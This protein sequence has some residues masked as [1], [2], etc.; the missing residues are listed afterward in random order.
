MKKFLEREIKPGIRL[1]NGNSVE[2][3]NELID[4]FGEGFADCII[5]DP[6]YG[7]TL[8]DE[9]KK[10]KIPTFKSADIWNIVWK[11]VKNDGAVCLF[12]EG[13][14][15]V[16]LCVDGLKYFRYNYCFDSKRSRGHLNCNRMPLLRHGLIGVF[17]KE[18]PTYNA[19]IDNEVFEGHY[20]NDMLH[21]INNK[22]DIYPHERNVSVLE[23]LIKTYTRERDIVFDFCMGAGSLAE[24][25]YRTKRRFIGVELIEDTFDKACQRISKL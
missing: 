24:A 3:V 18:R 12:N 13:I 21:Y 2:V 9:N 7:C 17:Y 16:K 8:E 19:Q 10:Y 6:P 4:E 5:S 14:G 23:F 11:S 1:I 22:K 15:F 20:P 25:C